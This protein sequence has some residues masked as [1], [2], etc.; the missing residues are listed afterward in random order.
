MARDPVRGE[1]MLIA[2]GVVLLASLGLT[3]FFVLRAVRSA[4]AAVVTAAPDTAPLAK[5]APEPPSVEPPSVEPPPEASPGLRRYATGSSSAA[6][7]GPRLRFGTATVSGRL[8]EAVVKRIVRQNFGRFRMCYEQALIPAPTLRG[9]LKVRFVIGR[10]GSV[11]VVTNAGT[12]LTDPKMVSCVL[13]GFHGL[14]FP[15]PES[16]IVA[17]VMPLEF[18]PA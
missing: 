18:E 10:D 2:V 7:R 17:V 15:S 3:A 8:P 14:A 6:P 5:R 12:D 9:S 11:S 4:P 1:G 13:A 16:G